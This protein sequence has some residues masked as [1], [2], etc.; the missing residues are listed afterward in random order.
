MFQKR[1]A[2]RVNQDFLYLTCSCIIRTLCASFV[3]S[4]KSGSSSQPFLH[5]IFRWSLP[6]QVF[7]ARNFSNPPHSCPASTFSSEAR[8]MPSCLYTMINDYSGRSIGRSAGEDGAGSG[9]S[10]RTAWRTRT[11]GAPTCCRTG[12]RGG[13]RLSTLGRRCRWSHRGRRWLSC[14]TTREPGICEIWASSP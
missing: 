13:P 12:K 4:R 10:G 1:N 7:N 2:P 14:C 9:P 11:C 6:R 5:W 3:V 8:W